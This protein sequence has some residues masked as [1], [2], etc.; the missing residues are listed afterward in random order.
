MFGRRDQ[1]VERG[2]SA[3]VTDE[4]RLEWVRARCATA[5]IASS[6]TQSRTAAPPGNGLEVLV[7]HE[8]DLDPRPLSGGGK[9]PAHASAAD[10]GQRR[11]HGGGEVIPFQFP[12]RRY[13]T[14]L[15]VRTRWRGCQVRASSVA[16]HGE[17]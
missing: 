12:H 13:Q 11:A 2:R 3:D 6:G 8:T 1:G 14:A 15:L 10:H 7:R 16:A 17:V 4:R 9:G 5:A